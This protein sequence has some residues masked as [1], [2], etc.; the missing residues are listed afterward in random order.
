[1]IKKPT[2]LTHSLLIALLLFQN[3][4]EKESN[5]PSSNYL[6]VSVD[7]GIYAVPSNSEIVINILLTINAPKAAEQKERPPIS[8]ALVIDKSGSMGEEK[9]LEYAKIAGKA[10]VGKLDP[11]DKL[12]IVTFDNKAT[13]LVPTSSVSN[14]QHLEKM[15][16]YIQPGSTTNIQ[17][18]LEVGI[19]QIENSKF[20]GTKRVV[21]LSDGNANVGIQ[22][23]NGISDIT[24]SHREKGITVSAVGLGLDYNENLMQAVAQRSGGQY[25]YCGEA[26]DLPNVFDTE[27]SL[28]KNTVTHKTR[29][30]IIQETCVNEVKIV[31][32]P[33]K[34]KD[35]QISVDLSDLIS[36][37]ERQI[38]FQL[39]VDP[40]AAIKAKSKSG[41]K[42][43]ESETIRLNL[44]EIHLQFSQTDTGPSEQIKIPLSVIVDDN[45][46]IREAINGDE[47]LPSYSDSY[48]DS[49]PSGSTRFGNRSHVQ[50]IERVTE[51]VMTIE[52]DA[53]KTLA[54]EEMEHGNIDGARYILNQYRYRQQGINQA[55]LIDQDTLKS[56]RTLSGS[57]ADSLASFMAKKNPKVEIPP[58]S[59]KSGKQT[60]NQWKFFRSDSDN[61][62]DEVED[63]IN[64]PQMQK[65]PKIAP[66]PSDSQQ[67]PIQGQ[68]NKALLKQQKR[69]D[70]VEGKFDAAKKDQKLRTHLLK[71]NKMRQKAHA[72]G[73]N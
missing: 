51:F 54:V 32:L 55:I 49:D 4:V 46:D 39:T 11:R 73:M 21:L 47:Q 67:S 5:I 31:G 61:I 22:D 41:S 53:A 8:V 37:E 66:I 26:H 57:V 59:A 62:E 60:K 36:E 28:A 18:G 44:G 35:S 12:T 34:K 10:L 70:E 9:K 68:I 19:N 72:Q 1:M 14:R 2:I 20:E 15:I 24:S 33:Q 69:L 23:P 25:Y 13:V 3:V 65:P 42:N 52:A 27:L 6:K 43:T 71:Q 48:S 17:E 30:S 64:S 50:S 38:L 45:E 29:A 40:S 7:Y 16:D 63:D 58:K 56:K